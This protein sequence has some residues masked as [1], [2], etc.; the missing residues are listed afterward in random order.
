MFAK[1][2]S[3][4][5][6]LAESVDTDALYTE[7]GSGGEDELLAELQE[8]FRIQFKENQQSIQDKLTTRAAKQIN[9]R[10]I[11]SGESNSEKRVRRVAY[12]HAEKAFV[13]YASALWDTDEFGEVNTRQLQL[14]AEENPNLIQWRDGVFDYSGR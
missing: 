1:T 7:V 6:A 5:I 2:E 9:D 3:E 10:T 11:Q 13:T 14:I 12:Q 8:S 4:A